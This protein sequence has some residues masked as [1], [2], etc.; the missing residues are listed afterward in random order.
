MQKYHLIIRNI[1]L[2]SGKRLRIISILTLLFLLA[3]I[4][5]T[6][7]ILEKQQ[8][9]RQHAA[10]T[11]CIR[12]NIPA[13][14][15]PGQLWQQTIS[16]APTGSIA[17]MN[18]N[19]GPGSSQD[20][21]YVTTV[22][23]AKNAG[24]RVLGYVHTS[25]GARSSATVKSEI[26]SYKSWYG[27]TDIFFDEVSD[28]STYYSYYQDLAN[29][30]HQTPN[31]IVE[32]NPG[33]Y[34]AEGYMSIG[35][36]VNVYEDT[37]ANYVNA[38]VPSW[39]SNYPASK[40]S[41]LVYATPDT[42]SMQNAVTLAKMRNVGYLYITNDNLP[43]PWDSLPTYW[44][45]EET[46]L[47]S[48]CNSVSPTLQPTPTPGSNRTVMATQRALVFGTP[49]DGN[50]ATIG[51]FWGV[52]T[53]T[54]T[55][56]AMS[57]DAIKAH[58]GMFQHFAPVDDTGYTD[59]PYSSFVTYDNAQVAQGYPSLFISA[60]Y[61][62]VKYPVYFVEGLGTNPPTQPSTYWLRAVNVADDRFVNWF[63]TNYVNAIMLKNAL[64][65]TWIAL[66]TCIFNYYDYGIVDSSGVYHPNVT[67]DSPYPQNDA[68]YLT[69]IQTFFQKVKQL[70]PNVH[71]ICNNGA[72][73]D[74][75]M[76]Q[77]IYTNIDGILQEDL[78]SYYIDGDSSSY[79]A[80]SRNEMYQIFQDNTWAGSQGK[81]MVYRWVLTND[82]T[83]PDQLRRAYTFYVMLQSANSFFDPQFGIP[84]DPPS[85][86]TAMQTAIGLP[87]ASTVVTQT[88]GQP[89]GYMLY[90]RQTQNAMVYLNWTSTTQT[91]TLPSGKSYVDRNGNPVSKLTIP[92]MQGD[93]ALYASS[94][95]PTNTP[96]PKPTSSPTPSVM[97]SATPTPTPLPGTTTL[98]FPSILLHGIGSAGDSVAPGTSGNTSPLTPNR[99]LTVQVV[100]ASNVLV[101]TLSGTITYSPSSGGFSGSVSLGSTVP[102]G[103]YLVKV[104]TDK[105]LVKQLPGII[106]LTQGQTTTIPPV[107]LIVGDINNDNTLNILDYN[108]LLGCYSDF[109][110]PTSCPGTNGKES[111][112]NDDGS[113]NASDY[114]LFLRELSVQSGE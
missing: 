13:Y 71:Y 109:L 85:D 81:V 62:G 74:Y 67:W 5:L 49:Y 60:T 38:Q 59:F 10:G 25:Y 103:S 4:P 41:H 1:K 51:F 15:S 7:S 34:P 92:D 63:L 77:P 106:T 75:S 53:D 113:V 2:T 3:I 45:G 44:S 48:T 91:V 22:T 61:S 68:Q 97:P 84:E 96:T 114:N 86:Y 50:F 11:T 47:N 87:V 57:P 9:V 20:S 33:V 110:P 73:G 17:I 76:F 6:V 93:Y 12:I 18:P 16:S 83:L 8:E 37:Y 100:N 64:P 70:A 65:N 99:T 31:A 108:I 30:V 101:T 79:G 94:P 78:N 40:F 26:D 58:Y 52:H 105:Y 36:I 14:F 90:S 89:S 29:Y 39:V 102:T 66:D 104:K 95:T 42:A 56:N 55:W 46:L 28:Q 27:V 107:S 80:Y 112:L 69:M 111:D 43:N 88:S 82:T 23:N 32:L 24:I 72:M 21:S 19:S 98:S 35:D 54:S